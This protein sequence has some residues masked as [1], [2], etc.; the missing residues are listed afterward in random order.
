MPGSSLVLP[1]CSWCIE[2][3]P[4]RK[5]GSSAKRDWI[6]SACIS[7]YAERAI[8]GYVLAS[9]VFPILVVVRQSY[10]RKDYAWVAVLFVP[11][12]AHGLVLPKLSLQGL[13]V[14]VLFGRLSDVGLVAKSSCNPLGAAADGLF[15]AQFRQVFD[16]VLSNAKAHQMSSVLVY[17]F[18]PTR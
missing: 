11:F 8:P 7:A 1:A 15:R 4:R 12:G 13:R 6:P 5:N 3:A 9:R 17:G 14:R 16:A 10:L 2:I 18:L